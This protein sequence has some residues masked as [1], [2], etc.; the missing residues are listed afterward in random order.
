MAVLRTKGRQGPGRQNSG[1][2]RLKLEHLETRA[3]LAGNVSVSVS[4]G[5]L[6]VRG[7]NSSNQIAIVQL[8]VGEYAVVGLNGTTVN[9]S[10]DPVVKS[11]VKNN[12][13]VDLKKGN[14]VVAIGNDLEALAL[15]A[16]ASEITL[17]DDLELPEGA[18]EC[19]KVP[20]HLNLRLG[21]GNDDAVVIAK[22]GL[23]INADLGNGNDRLIIQDSKVGDDII[24]RGG[25]GHDY[26]YT[27]RTQ[28][29]QMYDVNMGNGEDSVE[30]WNSSVGESVVI[31]TGN[32]ADY[33]DIADSAI[34]DNV[35][36]RTGNG[37]DEVYAHSHGAEGMVVDRNVDIDTGAG[38]DYVEVAGDVTKLVKV[39]AGSGHDEVFLEDLEARDLVVLL[40]AGNDYMEADDVE[41]DNNALLDASSGNDRAYIEKS[42]VN[43]LFTALMGSGNDLLEICN[44]YA[45]KANLDGGS[46]RDELRSDY[47]DPLPSSVK[48]KN[49]E[50]YSECEDEV[51][52]ET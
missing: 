41:I 23:R 33:V 29:A 38:N 42:A 28:V 52:T 39:N 3:M 22:V 6:N 49:F 34:E 8:D 1:E 51:V 2:R 4:G 45:K 18:P 43:N 14:D 30:L 15:W 36:V 26:L 44:S 35:I 9:G 12:I 46:G 32:D 48:V 27:N 16:D 21:D 50:L 37:S 11:G 40:G 17:P 25:N 5:N 13:D 31:N 20:K 10:T 19:L 47:P 7:N 24:V